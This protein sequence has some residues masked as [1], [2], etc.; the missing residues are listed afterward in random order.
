MLRRVEGGIT[1]GSRRA[2]PLELRGAR[3]DRACG[4]RR[5][6]LVVNADWAVPKELRAILALDNTLIWVKGPS[7]EEAMRSA[8]AGLPPDLVS[9]AVHAAEAAAA[10][11]R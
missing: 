11:A 8:L 3:V 6:I 2:S 10:L 1:G 5:S 4:V 7:T 9:A